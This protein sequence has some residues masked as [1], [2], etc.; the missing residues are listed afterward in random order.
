MSS[1]LIIVADLQHF[2]LFNIK[3]DPLKRK[4][5]EILNGSDNINYHQKLSDTVSD[6]KGNFQSSHTSGPDNSQNVSVAE[7]RR[8]MMGSGSAGENHNLS[9][10]QER[11]RLKEIANQISQTLQK[12]SHESW[13]FA[14]PKAI[15]NKIVELLDAKT[16]E[17]MKINLQSDLTNIPDSELLEYFSKK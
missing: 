12:H 14:A 9:L 17:R 15:N 1:D 5:V 6:R 3:E 10:E 4:S 7:D 16:K 11:R 2:K 8:R 13:Y